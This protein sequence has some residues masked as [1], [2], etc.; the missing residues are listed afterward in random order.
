HERLEVGGNVIIAGSASIDGELI[1]SNLNG[2]PD[3]LEILKIGED[4]VITR[5][6][7]A[8]FVG[9]IYEH[10]LCIPKTDESGTLFAYPAPTWSHNG[11]AD[12]G[13]IYTGLPC[14]AFVGINTGAPTAN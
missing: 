10:E 4:G 9:K 1:L 2:G 5:M 12:A 8:T 6:G 11:G 13:I 14:P 7:R 3:D